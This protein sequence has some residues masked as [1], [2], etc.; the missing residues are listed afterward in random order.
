MQASTS[1]AT[2][3]AWD[4]TAY[5]PPHG[6][7]QVS[8]AGTA[9]P[10]SNSGPSKSKKKPSARVVRDDWDN[11]D[12]EE[13]DNA[14]VWEKA[15]STV[16][17]P[18]L[19]IAPSSTSQVVS[20]PPAALQG[21][22]RILKRPS[23]ATSQNSA[24]PADSPR[25]TF[26]QREA[27]YQEARERIFGSSSKASDN[28]SG[29]GSNTPA[30]DSSESKGVPEDVQLPGTSGEQ[31]RSPVNVIRAPLGPDNKPSANGQQPKGF[32]DRRGKKK[33]PTAHLT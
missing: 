24:K 21:P 28:D 3:D 2:L 15:N 26:A 6:V 1:T 9:L 32:G 4:E 18:E 17:M 11:S 22:M 19:V 23:P 14:Q 31:M 25:N 29:S 20:P 8:T 30:K 27:Q 12:S 5:L 16:P 33:P 13:E 10:T 7:P